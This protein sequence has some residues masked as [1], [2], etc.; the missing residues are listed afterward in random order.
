[1]KKL[2]FNSIMFGLFIYPFSINKSNFKPNLN[3][4]S[5][6]NFSKELY[7]HVDSII[8]H[9][10]SPLTT[11]NLLQQSEKYEID[12]H[13]M[14][15]QGILESHLGTKGRSLKTNS[16]FG[17][18]MYDNKTILSYSHPDESVEPYTKLISEN[19]LDTKNGITELHLMKNGSYINKEGNR[20]ASYLSYEQKLRFIYNQLKQD[21][22]NKYGN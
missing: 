9:Y 17:V 6:S 1:M 21:F 7:Q 11:S 14:V 15:A 2:I 5:T 3:I 10:K 20:Y 8:K 13:F 12:I 4:P 18:G 16:V 22:K 19:Y